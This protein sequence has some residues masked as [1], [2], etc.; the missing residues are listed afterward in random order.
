LLKQQFGFCSVPQQKLC[1]LHDDCTLQRT[2]SIEWRGQ[3]RPPSSRESKEP[4][5]HIILWRILVCKVL[6]LGQLW[7]LGEKSVR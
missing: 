4:E 2:S 6:K 1:M 7:R 5:K 3:S